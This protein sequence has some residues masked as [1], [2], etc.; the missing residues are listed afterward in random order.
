MDEQVNYAYNE[1]C[2]QFQ[3]MKKEKLEVEADRIAEGLG[4]DCDCSYVGSET[5]ET[6]DIYSV[7]CELFVAAF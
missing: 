7:K 1:I 2:E 5:T 3:S 4:N 6:I